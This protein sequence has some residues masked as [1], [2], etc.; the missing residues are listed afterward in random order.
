VEA[1]R[2]ELGGSVDFELPAGG[3]AL[4]ARVDEALDTADWAA[5]AASHGVRVAPGRSFALEG[6]G[7][8]AFRLGFASLTPQELREAVHRL[9]L[10]R[11][12]RR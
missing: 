8:S 7:P 11:P 2:G 12:R 4:W 5:R 10:A 9:A 1:L 6:R 3:L